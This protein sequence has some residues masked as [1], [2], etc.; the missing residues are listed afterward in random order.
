MVPGSGAAG[1]GL[2]LFRIDSLCGRS[3]GRGRWL[4]LFLMVKYYY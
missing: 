3:P 4:K 1:L 2:G